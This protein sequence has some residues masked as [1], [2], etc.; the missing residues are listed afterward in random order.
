VCVCVCVCVCGVCVCICQSL[1]RDIVDTTGGGLAQF[2]AE[3]EKLQQALRKSHESETRFV[4]KCRE[5]TK[6]IQTSSEKTQVLSNLL[7]EEKR[8]IDTFSTQLAVTKQKKETVNADAEEVR[9]QTVALKS[10]LHKMGK[11]G[12]EGTV[13]L[14]KSQEEK[15]KLLEKQLESSI[16]CTYFCDFLPLPFVCSRVNVCACLS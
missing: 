15:V 16:E 7:E 9:L 8:Q 3:Y 2:I 13:A 4:N 11:E 14:E 6:Q 12:D 10:E 5:L 1:F